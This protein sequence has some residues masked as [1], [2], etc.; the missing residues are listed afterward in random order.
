MCF[1]ETTPAARPSTE[2]DQAANHPV[3][4]PGG[5]MCHHFW[6]NITICWIYG[7]EAGHLLFDIKM[8]IKG[9]YEAPNT[10]P[11]I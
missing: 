8:S 10:R 1:Q 4:V 6:P 5:T 2:P 7:L 3:H 11:S 9:F